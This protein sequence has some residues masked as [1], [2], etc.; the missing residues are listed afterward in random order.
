MSIEE[1][2][3]TYF[4]FKKYDFAAEKGRF[5]RRGDAPPA[6]CQHGGGEAWRGDKDGVAGFV[7]NLEPHALCGG[8]DGGV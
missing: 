3:L 6:H 2:L 8:E 4:P 5:V 1:G 7:K